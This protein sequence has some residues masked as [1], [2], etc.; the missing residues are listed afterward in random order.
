VIIVLCV[1]YPLGVFAA[2]RWLL[3]QPGIL[4]FRRRDE[5]T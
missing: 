3:R 2:A 5:E 1:L 4:R